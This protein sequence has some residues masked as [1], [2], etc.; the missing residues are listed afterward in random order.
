MRRAAKS[1]RCSSCGRKINK[2]DLYEPQNLGKRWGYYT[3]KRLC[4]RC[5]PSQTK[6]RWR[7]RYARG[8]FTRNKE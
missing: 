2:G 8:A 1:Y 3:I 4:E 7:A 6:S 5:A